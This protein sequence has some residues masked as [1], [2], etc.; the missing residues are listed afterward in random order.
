M[1][2]ALPLVLAT[3]ALLGALDRDYSRAGTPLILLLNWMVCTGVSHMCGDS[4]PWLS[5]IMF[6][7]LAALGVV[8]LR[9]THWQTTVIVLYATELL[10]HAAYGLSDRGAAPTYYGYYCL[11][12]LAWAQVAVCGGWTLY[13]LI[14]SRGGAYNGGQPSSLGVEKAQ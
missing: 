6:D 8:I 11:L 4:Y 9:T 2:Q 13:D 1:W 7:Y 12:Y 14:G 3:L 5:F 10:C